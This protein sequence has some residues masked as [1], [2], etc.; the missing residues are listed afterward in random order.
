[1][2]NWIIHTLQKYNY[3]T[4]IGGFPIILRVPIN[5]LLKAAKRKLLRATVKFVTLLGKVLK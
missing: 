2:Q 4:F 1:M 3:F 5:S